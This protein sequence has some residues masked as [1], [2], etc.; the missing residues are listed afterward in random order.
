[1]GESK[2]VSSLQ[3]MTGF[4]RSQA[5]DGAVAVAV[6]IKSVNNKGLD[7]RLRYSPGHDALD[8]PLRRMIQERFA[9]GSFQVNVTVAIHDMALQP[10]IN[11]PFLARLIELSSQ[12]VTTH[13]TSPPSADGLL[14]IRGV[15]EMPE[16][17]LDDEARAAVLDTATKAM[18]EALDGVRQARLAEGNAIAAVLS[19]RVDEIA[20]LVARAEAD[21]SRDK[22]VI[23]AR[24]KTQVEQLLDVSSALDPARLH[25][26][27]ALLATKADIREELD[28][29]H[30]HV[31][32]A[33]KLIGDGGAVGRKLDFLAQEINR[34]SNTLCSKSNAVSVTE[35]GLQLKLA[36]D[37]FREQ[38]QNV[39]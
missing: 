23:A 12:L 7:I 17:E 18:G 15:I 33:R 8:L 38:V 14:A 32:A 19:S 3:S 24:M 39:E 1:M 31:A 30:A 34:E 36:V 28:R 2:P 37:Q 22:D 27:A 11:E 5:H 26:E 25:A 29:L 10:R 21:P 6:E 9:R 13:S 16:G 20:A 35:I 4:A